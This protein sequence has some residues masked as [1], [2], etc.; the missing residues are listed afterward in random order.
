M[1]A[2]S[3]KP[4]LGAHLVDGGVRFA[5]YAP[6]AEAVDLCLYNHQG[7]QTDR[8]TLP[9][10]IDGVWH[11]FV[12]HCQPG[13]RYGYRVRGPYAPEEGHRFDPSKLLIDP[14]ARELDGPFRWSDELFSSAESA[15]ADDGNPQFD[16]APFVPKGVVTPEYQVRRAAPNISWAETLVYET[17]VR[18]H[19]MRHPDVP[20]ADR[21]RFAGMRNAEVL[22]YLKALG[23]TSIELMP[24]HYFV[25]EIFLGQRGLTNHWGYNTLSFFAPM[26]RYAQDQPLVELIDMI[27]TIHDAGLEVIMDVVYNHTCEGNQDGP[28]LSLRGFNNA[29]YY[30]LAPHNKSHFINDTGCGNTLNVDHPAM[31]NLTLDSLRYFAD[32]L[33]IDGF[34]F[35]LAPVLGR[36]AGGFT[37]KHPFFLAIANDPLLKNKK[38]IAEPWDVGP[39]GYQLGNFPRPWAQWND[40]YRDG[41]RGFWRGDRHSTAEF[42]RRL[43]GSSDLFEPGGRTPAAGINL[44]SAHDGYTLLDVVSYERKHNEANGEDNQD[45]HNNNLSSNYGVEG[46]TD[47]AKILT[48]RRRQR[49]NMLASLFWSHG[50]PM[51]LAGDEFGHTQGGNNNA[52]AQDNETTWLDWSRIDDDPDFLE[53]VRTLIALRRDIPLLRKAR[54]LHGLSKTRSGY[55]NID[56]FNPDGTELNDQHWHHAR[57]ITLALRETITGKGPVTGLALLFNGTNRTVR[58]ALPTMEPGG[59]WAQRF[60][61]LQGA[62]LKSTKTPASVSALGCSLWAYSQDEG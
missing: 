34:R 59:A 14:Y 51:L 17:H 35:D 13:Q 55:P 30:R 9:D 29:G 23:I 21:G 18:G 11:G 37:P 42:A 60:N 2:L 32:D 10:Q 54:Y 31:L 58:F 36:H 27:Q 12:A 5:V 15:A 39:G 46:D 6:D 43:H 41:V 4:P 24:I 28:T 8:L 48:L 19:T 1:N 7:Q 47:D 22:R 26:N 33:Q 61:S 49:L 56:W 44:V 62:D 40:Q 20:Q 38:M 16:S 45:G 53:Q 52:Y 3:A 25:D 57:A 50:T